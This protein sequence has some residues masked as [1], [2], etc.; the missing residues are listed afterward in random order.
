[1]KQ[2][3]HIFQKDFRHLWPALLGWFLTAAF[4]F[5][6]QPMEF[7]PDYRR[8]N[9]LGGDF[10]FFA[11]F[12]SWLAIVAQV[13]HHEALPGT[14][15]FWLA[16]PYDWRS[17]LGAKLL[18]GLLCLH[19]PLLVLDLACLARNGLSPLASLPQ[20]LD[21]HLLLFPFL[22]VLPAAAAALTRNLAQFA[23]VAVLGSAAM[24]IGV[25]MLLAPDRYFGRLSWVPSFASLGVLITAAAVVVY[26]Q[27]SKRPH[28]LG[29]VLA[30]T[31]LTG[32]ILIAALVP[33]STAT[34]VQRSLSPANGK[35]LQ[36]RIAG[37]REP[38]KENQVRP[39]FVRVRVPLRVEGLGD[40]DLVS[41]RLTVRI[42]DWESS[43][44]EN[45]R[46]D[47]KDMH[48]FAQRFELP[49]DVYRRHQHEPVRLVSKAFVST[50]VRVAD[51]TVPFGVT[52][53]VPGVGVCDSREQQGDRP[54]ISTVAVACRVPPSERERILVRAEK[55][56]EPLDFWLTLAGGSLSPAGMTVS[57]APVQMRRTSFSGPRTDPTGLLFRR[58][59]LEA[60]FR[61]EWTFDQFKL[62][63]YVT[64]E[65]D[66]GRR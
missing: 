60:S 42:G 13:V 65:P 35:N 51:A 29:Q 54:G 46:L 22:C 6:W 48:D 47:R 64:W 40:R 56:G 33:W 2:A 36:M 37:P 57:I 45:M 41:D 44:Q 23:L 43:S 53:D 12:V 14:T 3:W 30:V 10:V 28:R 16:R 27:Y 24:S 7:F 55:T 15:Q 49:V 21:R 19:L 32:A 20:L 63:D 61:V 17:L 11:A 58:M 8:V 39:G 50:Y 38:Y 59:R 4:L 34:A 9:V 66:Q 25:A 1:M 18:F 62:S 26:L 5:T 52:A 31:G